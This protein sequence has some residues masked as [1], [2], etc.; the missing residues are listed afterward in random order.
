[1]DL[2]GP[3]EPMPDVPKPA[4]TGRQNMEV[5]HLGAAAERRAFGNLA[6]QDHEQSFAD[7]LEISRDPVVWG[8]VLG[9]VLADIEFKLGAR[10]TV[11]IE[12]AGR[13][14]VDEAAAQ[15]QLAWRRAQPR[16]MRPE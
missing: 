6:D 11:I 2:V 14:G 13:A 10:K 12:W 16:S 1:M 5:A 4:L 3:S 8:V 7:L 9:N 15:Q